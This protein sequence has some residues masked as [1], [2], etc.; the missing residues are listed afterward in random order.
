MTSVKATTL[1]SGG[2]VNASY[3]RK[4]CNE[5]IS[6]PWIIQTDDYSADANHDTFLRQSQNS[7][8][9]DHVSIRLRYACVYGMMFIERNS[10]AMLS[11]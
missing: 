4:L 10:N 1:P 7:N 2:D 5:S 11:K 6:I 3:N 9:R 8:H